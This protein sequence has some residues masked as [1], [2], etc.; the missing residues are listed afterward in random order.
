MDGNVSDAQGII[1][2]VLANRNSPAARSASA[3]NVFQEVRAADARLAVLSGHGGI[4]VGAGFSP[5]GRR[6]VTASVDQTVRIWDAATATQLALLSG[7]STVSVIPRRS[8]PTG[9][10]SSPPPKT[11][12]RA[13][14]T[15]SRP[16]RSPCSQVMVMRS[17]PPHFRPTGGA[18]SPP[19]KTRP[20]GSGTRPRP[21]SSPYSPAM[22]MASGR[23]VFARWAAHRHRLPRPDRAD[24]GRGHGQAARRALRS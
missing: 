12:P 18:S 19:P 6:I 17:T 14:G 11:R 21:S 15:R 1:V 5:D 23:R 3:I 7:H 4:V 2:D 20:R 13:S 8:R 24:L 9:G 22:T 10:A 16:G